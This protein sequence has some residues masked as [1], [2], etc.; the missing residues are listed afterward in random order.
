M[1]MLF[2]PLWMMRAIEAASLPRSALVNIPKL[3]GIV[4]PEDVRLY[5]GI[6]GRLNDV[7][8]APIVDSFHSSVDCLYQT[9]NE[10][11][12]TRKRLELGE[13]FNAVVS[14]KRM[15]DSAAELGKYVLSC[16]PFSEDTVLIYQTSVEGSTDMASLYTDVMKIL[17]TKM[18]FEELMTEPCARA[19]L[20]HTLDQQAA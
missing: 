18:P 20:R 19:W 1:K 3:L 13:D 5:V 17:N 11:E 16:Y 8:P 4:S 10:C 9:A 7:L 6:N 15:K 2:A 14:D 12:E